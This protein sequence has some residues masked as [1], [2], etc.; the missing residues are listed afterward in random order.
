LLKIR[1]PICSIQVR[2]SQFKFKCDDEWDSFDR[3]AR[4]YFYKD[5]TREWVFY[6]DKRGFQERLNLARDRNLQGFC[7]WV[8]GG[9]DPEIWTVLPSHK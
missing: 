3:T 7:S 4:F 5:D 6:T 8:L 9:E 2:P 1:C